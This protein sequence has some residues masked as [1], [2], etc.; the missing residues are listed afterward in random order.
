MAQCLRS[1]NRMPANPT[2]SVKARHTVRQQLTCLEGSNSVKSWLI[3]FFPL[4][5]N[6]R[7]NPAKT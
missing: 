6:L 5:V 1:W 3:T 7:T 2:F 4:N